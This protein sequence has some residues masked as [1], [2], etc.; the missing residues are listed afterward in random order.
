MVKTW[1]L[2]PFYDI[3]NFIFAS[4]NS[5]LAEIYIYIYLYI[6]IYVFYISLHIKKRVAPHI[7]VIHN[8]NK[9]NSFELHFMFSNQTI[10]ILAIIHS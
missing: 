10:T 5:C 1:H 7:V 6:Y 4:L 3:F 2:K 9:T 8:L